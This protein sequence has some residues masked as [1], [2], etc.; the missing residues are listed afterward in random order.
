MSHSQFR[1]IKQ[2]I[3]RHAWLNLWDKH[4]TTGR[5][6]Q[7]TAV[8]ELTENLWELTIVMKTSGGQYTRCAEGSSSDIRWPYSSLSSSEGTQKHFPPFKV[9][10]PDPR[11][12]STKRTF[13]GDHNERSSGYCWDGKSTSVKIGHPQRPH[14]H[15][16]GRSTYHVV[17]RV[18]H[19]V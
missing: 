15:F 7:V 10:D 14:H 2:F 17:I 8:W 1:S 9:D 5:I 3:L 19:L 16:E 6:N 4:M 18:N 13:Q 11:K 12:N